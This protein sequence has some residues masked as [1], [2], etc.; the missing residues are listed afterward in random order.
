MSFSE[1]PY[2]HISVVY[3]NG[4]FGWECNS[5]GADSRNRRDPARQEFWSGRATIAEITSA[6]WNHI[7][8]SHA[9]SSEDTKD[10]S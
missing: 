1:D 6:F 4:V 7:R 2:K 3:S 8:V 5:C 9:L 10:W